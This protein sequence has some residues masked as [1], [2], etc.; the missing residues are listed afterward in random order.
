MT[1]TL[2]FGILKY[3]SYLEEYWYEQAHEILPKDSNWLHD[4]IEKEFYEERC[5]KDGLTEEQTKKVLE[6]MGY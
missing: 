5:H 4:E 3:V 6:V 1:F 2:I